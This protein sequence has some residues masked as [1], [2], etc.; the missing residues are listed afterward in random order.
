VIFS[1]LNLQGVFSMMHLKSLV[2]ASAIVLAVGSTSASAQSGA[3]GSWQLTLQTPQGNQSV[4]LTLAQTGNALSGDLLSPMGSVPVTG[5]ATGD[6]V[7][8]TAKIE[9]MNIELGLNGKVVA[10]TIEGTVKFGDFGEFPFTGK[11]AAPR[12]TASAAPSAP[13][14]AV[15]GALDDF[16]G[17][18]DVKIVIAGAGEFPATAT[19]KQDGDKVSGSLN[20]MAGEVAVNG[21]VIGR[22]LK[23]EFEADT[24]QGKLPITLTGDLGVSGITGKANIAGLGEADWTATRAANQ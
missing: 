15:A 22:S 17:K 8:V 5:T 21:T 23:V 13:A 12:A 10:D 7:A 24:P 14:A 4:D 19:L 6:T 16:N 9:A 3:A 11:R 20:S 1:S 18:W 2:A